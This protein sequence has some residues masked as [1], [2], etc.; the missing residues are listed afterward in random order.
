LRQRA[1]REVAP[2]RIITVTSG[3]GGVGKTNM[4]INLG[5]TLARKNNRVLLLDVDLGLANVEVLLGISSEYN[6]E[7]VVVG[8]KTMNEIIVSGP[9][10]VSVIPGSSG[11]SGMADLDDVQRKALIDSFDTLQSEADIIIVDTMAGMSRNVIGFTLAADEVVLVTTPEPSAVLDAYAMIKTIVSQDELAIIRLLVNMCDNMNHARKVA[12]RIVSVA[13]QFLGCRV[14]VLGFVPR[15]PNVSRAV[16]GKIPVIEAFPNTAAS[17]AI[18]RIAG[19]I[20]DSHMRSV[21]VKR[22]SFMRRLADAFGVT[23]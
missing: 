18:S 19:T 3:K 14:K 12:D 20:V 13:K 2:A 9:G 7:D 6:L 15:D 5:I 10:G 22:F 11:V 1:E 21:P 16:M 8:T 23:G 4:V 17:R